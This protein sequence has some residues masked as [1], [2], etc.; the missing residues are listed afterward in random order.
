MA[1]ELVTVPCRTDNYAF[2][3]HDPASGKTLLVDAPET[4]PIAAALDTR[5]WT[6]DT[7]LITH[8]HDDHID[9]VEDLRARYG[10]TV[11]GGAADT[12]RLPPL[13]SAVADGDRIDFAGHPIDV[14]DVYGHTVGH[15]AFHMPKDGL[16]FTADSLMAL[17][18]GRLFE[19]SYEQ[20]WDSLSRLAALPPQTLICSGHEYTSSNA[21]F[22]VTIEPQNE[23]LQHR[24][25]ATFAAAEAGEPTVPSLLS[26]E[27]ATN[28]FLRA[29]LAEVKSA[30]NMSNATDAEVFGEIRRRKDNF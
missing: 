14:I 4:A 7:L 17:G 3:V 10:C 30:L 20:M 29:G 22:A 19:G 2:L 11:I 18:C 27:L 23:A 24:A 26:L 9:A 8:H 15:I 12:H 1:L 6:L 5:G 16:A 28:P 13:D 25:R 21:R